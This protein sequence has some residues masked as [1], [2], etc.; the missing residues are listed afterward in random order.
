MK[1]RIHWVPEMAEE[2]R[3]PHQR[4]YIQVPTDET[5]TPPDLSPRSKLWHSFHAIGA[6]AWRYLVALR[7]LF[8]QPLFLALFSIA[9]GVALGILFPPESVISWISRQCASR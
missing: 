2:I 8:D 9:V 3:G 5:W 4:G 7:A 1:K 6:F